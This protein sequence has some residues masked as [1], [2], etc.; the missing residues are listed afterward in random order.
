MNGVFLKEGETGRARWTPTPARNARPTGGRTQHS[1]R[2]RSNATITAPDSNRKII[3][4]I[5]KYAYEH[6][7]ETGRFPKILIFAVNDLPHTSHADQLVDICRDVF[8][9]GDDF[10][11]KITGN[12]TSI[13]RCSASASSATAPKPKVVVTVDMLTT[14]V[15]I[16]DLE[17]IVFLRPVK[18]RILFEQMLGR[19]TRRCDES[20][21]KSHFIVFDCFDGTLIEYFRNITSIDS[22]AAEPGTP[23][24][25]A[26]RSSRTSG[27]TSDRDYNVGWLVK[28]LH[29]IEKK[30]SGDAREEFARFIPDGDVSRFADQLPQLI[31]RRISPRRFT[32]LRRTRNFKTCCRITN[33]PR[34][35][36]LVAIEAEDMVSSRDCFAVRQPRK[37]GRLSRGLFEIRQRERR[38]DHGAQ[39]TVW[40]VRGS[41]RPKR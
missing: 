14:G 26:G 30:M 8:D 39:N 20:S 16:P 31:A 38:P 18:S 36:F 17:F 11:Q 25:A 35:S 4:E 5:A 1:T 15:D 34:T 21:D 10:V 19:G 13:A 41:G 32:L 2:G 33:A 40:S 6:E 22:R 9:Q 27:R 37:A 7:A 29:R 3:E 12:R 23:H 28:R 24:D